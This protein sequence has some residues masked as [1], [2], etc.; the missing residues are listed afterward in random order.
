M[1]W[2]YEKSK[3]R[4]K[5]HLDGMGEIEIEKLVR[6]AD[7]QSL[8]TET[9]CR[10]VYGAHVYA[11]VSNFPSL[12]AE[13]S[14]GD[15]YRRLIQAIHIY[16]REVSRIVE[17]EESYDG[18][19]V[20]FQGPKVHTLLY[21]PIDDG[22]ELATR[23]FLIQLVLRDF[24]RN[25]FNP[26]FPNFE[27]FVL[28][29]GA[30]IGDAIGTRN[31]QKA[32]RELLFLGAP[33]N[34]AAKI[35][36]GNGYLR[37]T[38]TVFTALPQSLQDRC[39][40]VGDGED[41]RIVP[42]DGEELQALVEAHG[43]TWNPEKSAERIEEE[44][45]VFPLK[46]IEYSSA[47][48]RIV[49]DDLSVRNNKR[50]KGATIFADVSGFT[51]FVDDAGDD[52]TK[53]RAALRVF[54]AIRKEMSA[55]VKNDFEGVRVQFQ[56]DRVQ[57]LLHVPRDEHDKISLEAVECSAGL[58]QSME[59][60]LKEALPEAKSLHLAIGIDRGTTLAS[61]LGTRGHRD[62]ICLGQ[63]VEDAA[64]HEE[65]CIGGQTG[66]GRSVYDRL[67][68]EVQK[69]FSW[70]EERGCYVADALNVVKLARLQEAAAL[71]E[72]GR[73]TVTAGASGVM[74]TSRGGSGREVVPARSYCSE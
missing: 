28:S 65:R 15:E 52:R 39:A 36:R 41:Y 57:G 73:V 42:V 20:H 71:A 14:T 68:E 50:V 63:A 30:D 44:K 43:H 70:D 61:R 67:P 72:S 2:S 22:Q 66:I 55:V 5:K 7:L 1:G 31:G 18:L 33:A 47:T 37:V 10:E 24:V 12:A 9:R 49:F 17:K 3:E 35:I 46:D 64:D 58:H 54:H 51:A 40:A 48:E 13:I 6:E 29:A 8:L 53:Q 21:R 16:Q 25:V 34:R 60:T 4:I 11:A 74:V 19:R 59:T 26:A 62:R 45:E 23:A 38:D 56:G 32:D 27:N 69:T